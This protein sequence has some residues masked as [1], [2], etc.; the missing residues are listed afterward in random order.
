MD[1]IV[2]SE[3]HIFNVMTEK[4]FSTAPALDAHVVVDLRGFSARAIHVVPGVRVP[5]DLVLHAHAGGT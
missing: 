1:E 2:R 5:P 3:L 4:F